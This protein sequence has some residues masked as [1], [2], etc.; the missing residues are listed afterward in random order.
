MQNTIEMAVEEY[1]PLIAKQYYDRVVYMF[2]KMVI[3]RGPTLKGI[4]NDAMWGRTYS[5]LM[6]NFVKARTDSDMM[7]VV[8]AADQVP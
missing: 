1:K 6:K 2:E 4:Y 8:E 3:R 7:H 5:G